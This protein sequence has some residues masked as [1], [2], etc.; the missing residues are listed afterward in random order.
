MITCLKLFVAYNSYLQSIHRRKHQ[1]LL[2]CSSKT[3]YNKKFVFMWKLRN[4][5][6]KKKTPAIPT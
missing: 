2:M 3:S 6:D 4:G 1:M 5:S